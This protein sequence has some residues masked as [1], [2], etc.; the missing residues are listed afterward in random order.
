MTAILHQ[1][2][3]MPTAQLMTHPMMQSSN[4]LPVNGCHTALNIGY[5]SSGVATDSYTMILF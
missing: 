3:A 5:F 2:G 1:H 4:A